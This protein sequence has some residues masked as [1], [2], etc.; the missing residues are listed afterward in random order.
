MSEGDEYVHVGPQTDHSSEEPL[1]HVQKS[2][3]VRRL[4]TVHSACVGA[5]SDRTPSPPRL[6]QML[7]RRRRDSQAMAMSEPAMD[8]RRPSRL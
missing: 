4:P 3:E 5:R 8:R 6:A 7:R 1:R 2:P